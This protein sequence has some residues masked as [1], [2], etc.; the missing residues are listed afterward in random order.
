MELNF[1]SS[2]L[3]R[4]E[5]LATFLGAPAILAAGCT[6]PPP[7]LPPGEIIGPSQAVGH[8]LR[9][10]FRPIPATDAWQSVPV[11]IVGGGVAGLSAAW[12][13][14]RAG[15]HDFRLLELE[16]EPGGTARSGSSPIASYPW[17]AHYLPVPLATN[18]ALLTLLREMGVL[19]GLDAAGEPVIAEQHLCRDP[20]ERIFFRGQWYEGLYLHVGAS[21]EDEAEF[22][23]FQKEVSRWADWRDG[24]GRRAFA[25]P[26][27]NASDDAE[28][29]A[30][31]K[32]TMADWLDKHN[33]H[34][35]RL[36][37]LVNY[38]CRDDYGMTLDQ[39]SAWAGLFYFAAR[40]QKGG[41]EA[42]PLLTWPEGNGRL[43]SHLNRSVQSQVLLGQ[44]VTE[45]I[46]A[47][48]GKG[49]VEVV[50]V[51]GASLATGSPRVQ[52][53]RADQII[54]AAPQFLSRYLV[55]PYREKPPAHVNSFEYG[56]WMVANLFLKDRPAENRGYPLAWDNVL[57]ESPALGYVTA[58]HQKGLDHG[59]TILTYY[60]PLCDDSPRVAREKLLSL[61]RDHWPDVALTDLSRAHQ[62]IH[63]LTERVDIMRWGHAMIRPKPGFL[64]GTDRR[65]AAE[66]F[67]NIY[68]AHSDLSGLPLFEEAFDRGVRAAE[69]VLT[70]RGVK[71]ESIL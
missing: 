58:T 20:Q 65:A 68:F 46:P 9:D 39:T 67:H 47:A 38:A 52:G 26:I 6:E 40:L 43:I 53:W 49:P 44:A 5:L 57:Y 28:V 70:A 7:P 3:S 27:A 42:Q 71:F 14:R 30:L 12:R 21:P 31:D 50:G 17:G 1:S 35:P 15:F 48:T 61:Q 13:L 29:T 24:K 10:G 45:V 23:A 64:W 59:P 22:K 32:Q 11:V 25:I 19:E 62:D 66:P 51:D 34:S 55:R 2:S 41:E 4:R 60:Y 54:F 33:W 63:R 18:K 37:W 56:A 36:R 8:K 69:Q 16:P